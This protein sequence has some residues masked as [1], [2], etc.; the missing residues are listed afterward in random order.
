MGGTNVGKSFL[1]NFIANQ[2]TSIVSSM[3]WTTTDVVG[4]QMELNP[5]DKPL[6]LK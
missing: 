3:A 1:M 5:C 4:K 2:K 6:P